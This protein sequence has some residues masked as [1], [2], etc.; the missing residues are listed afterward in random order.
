MRILSLSRAEFRAHTPAVNA[1]AVQIADPNQPHEDILGYK[2]KHMTNFWDVEEEIGPYKPISQTKAE[3][4][5]DFLLANTKASELV[6]HCEAGVSR[7]HTVAVFMA[8]HIL[9]DEVLA[10]KLSAQTGKSINLGL[11]ASLIRALQNKG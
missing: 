8:Q 4:L 2:R 11:Y 6:V 7:S 5:V 9:N 3:L 1:V 10:A